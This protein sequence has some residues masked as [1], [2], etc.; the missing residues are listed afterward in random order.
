MQWPPRVQEI[1]DALAQG[2]AHSAPDDVRR[3][4]TEKIAQ[5][6]RFELGPNWGWKRA[7]PGRPL[8]TDVFCTREPFVGWDWSIPSGIATFPESIDLTGQVFVEV[9]P[10]NHLGIVPAPGPIAPNPGTITIV[11]LAEVTDIVREAMRPLMTDV[12]SARVEIAALTATVGMLSQLLAALQMR[13]DPY[14]KL[15]DL[16]EQLRTLEVRG[17]NRPFTTMTLSNVR[18]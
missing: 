18:K 13:H 5:Q 4:T 8:S 9:E 16:E 12:T 10:V 1:V 17:G 7:D 2:V 15:V 14:P 3:A 6:C 11:D